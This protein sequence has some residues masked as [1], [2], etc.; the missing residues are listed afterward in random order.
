MD[1]YVD[2][3]IE[4]GSGGWFSDSNVCLQIL[5]PAYRAHA[6]TTNR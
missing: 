4:G 1:G 5:I 6:M 3:T 2:S